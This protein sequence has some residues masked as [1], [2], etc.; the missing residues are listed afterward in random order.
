MCRTARKSRA[1][2][3]VKKGQKVQGREKEKWEKIKYFSK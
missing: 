2:F 1:T 3:C